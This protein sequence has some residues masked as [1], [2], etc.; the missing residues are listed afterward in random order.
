MVTDFTTIYGISLG[1]GTYN[2]GIKTMIHLDAHLPIPIGDE[3]VF[4]KDAINTMVAWPRH[5]VFRPNDKAK[6][7]LI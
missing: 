6:C 2:I 4:V 5:L 1:H 3:I 7:L